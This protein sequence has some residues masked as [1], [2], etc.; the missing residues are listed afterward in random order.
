LRAIV[1]LAGSWEVGMHVNAFAAGD[2]Y[3]I[4]GD[5]LEWR[6]QRFRL[7]GYDTP[8]VK[9][10]RSQIDRELEKRRGELAKLRLEILIAASS[11]VHL[12]DWGQRVGPGSR[13]LA[14]LLLDGCDVGKIAIKEGWAVDYQERKTVD[15]GD[16]SLVFFGVR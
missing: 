12:I 10:Q 14:T 3:V 11:R 7:A 2:L 6:G 16:H 13:Q 1:E 9:D 5:D 4:D 8:E 15:W